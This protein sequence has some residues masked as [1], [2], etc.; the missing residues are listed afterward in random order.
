MAFN[1]ST[2]GKPSPANHMRLQIQSSKYCLESFVECG[3]I[4]MHRLASIM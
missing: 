1:I 2:S 3:I 4:R